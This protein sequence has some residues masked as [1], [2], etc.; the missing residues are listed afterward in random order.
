MRDFAENITSFRNMG[1]LCCGLQEF[2]LLE[3]PW[4]FGH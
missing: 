1:L 3:K 4:P 2:F